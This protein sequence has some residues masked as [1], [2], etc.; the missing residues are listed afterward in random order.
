MALEVPLSDVLREV[1]DA[2]AVQ[3]AALRRELAPREVGARP[4]QVA[5]AAPSDVVASAA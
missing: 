2:V 3:E 5:K 4:L 1:S